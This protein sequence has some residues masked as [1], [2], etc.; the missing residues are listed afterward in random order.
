MDEWKI[1]TEL[2]PGPLARLLGAKTVQIH[3]VGKDEKWFELPHRKRCDP[4]I[5]MWLF[6]RWNRAQKHRA[7]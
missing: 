5:E 4:E 6:K 1:R 3:Y 7:F 2:V